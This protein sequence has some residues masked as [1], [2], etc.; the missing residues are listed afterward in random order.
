M[1]TLPKKYQMG[2]G[3]EVRSSA[4]EGGATNSSKFHNPGGKKGNL[5]TDGAVVSG[6]KSTHKSTMT[7]GGYR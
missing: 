4:T 7:Q 5:T 1:N 2:G 6:K 3:P